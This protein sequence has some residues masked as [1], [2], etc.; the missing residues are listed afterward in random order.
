MTKS[1]VFSAIKH[2]VKFKI[3]NYCSQWNDRFILYPQCFSKHLIFTSALSASFI[4]S[5]NRKAHNVHKSDLDLPPRK[6][7]S[8]VKK[9]IP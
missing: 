5:R 2:T 9:E 3:R 7:W 4:L 8:P 1:S 6:L